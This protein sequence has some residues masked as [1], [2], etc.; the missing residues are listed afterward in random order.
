MSMN[1]VTELPLIL[2]EAKVTVGSLTIGPVHPS[3]VSALAL[4][5]QVDTELLRLVQDLS[6][7]V[8]RLQTEL[9]EL[10]EGK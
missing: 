3:V 9:R 5:A 7:Q 8:Q 10:R 1:P 6:T 4:H 2:A